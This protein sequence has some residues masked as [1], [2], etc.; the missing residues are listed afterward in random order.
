M[1]HA[2]HTPGPWFIEHLDW[3]QKGHVF[4]SAKDH[5]ELAQVVWLMENDE[6]MGRN[7]PEKE[8]N[9]RLIAAAPTMLEALQDCRE[10]LRRTGHDGELA[11]VDAAIAKATGA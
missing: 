3:A 9:A 8:A 11:I 5:G 4:I 1:T 10:A 2:K 7:S 6:I